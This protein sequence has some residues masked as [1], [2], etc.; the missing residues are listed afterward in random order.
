M[1]MRPLAISLALTLGV[2]AFATAQPVTR[3]DAIPTVQVM[4]IG[5]A[6]Q[7]ADWASIAGVVRAQAKDQQAALKLIS[8]KKDAI[9]ESIA[10]LAGAKSITVET[11]QLAFQ[12]VLPAACRGDQPQYV[13]DGDVPPPNASNC[14]PT[15][16][17]GT[18]VLTVKVQ[19]AEQLGALA[20]LAVQLGLEDVRMAES[21]VDDP[22]A[23][24]A[25]A[26]R[27][28]YANALAQATLLADAANEHLGRLMSLNRGGL[29]NPVSGL[30][31]RGY[32]D[33]AVKMNLLQPR[34]PI[35][36]D[37][38]LNLTPPKVNESSSVIV[39]F[40]LLK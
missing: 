37:T 18:I 31:V 23:L 34:P 30:R 2:P 38:A 12:L 7:P 15:G 28:A 33:G 39:E 14:A 26:E 35:T 40:E 19:P 25:K 24:Q 3:S 27:A 17:E 8:A 1:F 21:G 36:P 10:R 11:S 20:S 9:A 6:E 22:A 4:G 29:M 5:T 13:P 16:V 32:A